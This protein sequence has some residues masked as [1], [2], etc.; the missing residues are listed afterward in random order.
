M[1]R[2]SPWRSG[3]VHLRRC[4]RRPLGTGAGSLPLCAA[5]PRAAVPYDTL[6]IVTAV[7]RTL[8]LLYLWCVT[9]YINICIY[10]I[11]M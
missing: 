7:G 6:V 11:Y 4:S 10:G 1:K 9:A 3:V 2:F 8:Y 5:L